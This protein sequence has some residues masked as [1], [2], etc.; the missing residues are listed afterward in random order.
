LLALLTLTVPALLAQEC[1]CIWQGP[2]IKAQQHADLVLLGTVVRR[3]GNSFDV[4][5]DDVMRGETFL[6]TVRVWGLYP[7]TC[8]PGVAQFTPGSQ[9]VL[10]LQ[11]IDSVPPGGF[12]INTPNLSY[13]RKG[14]Y[15]LSRCGIFWLPVRDGLVRG[16]LTE[17]V[18]WEFDEAPMTPVRPELIKRWLQGELDETRLI[19][20]ARFN[21]AVRQLRRET[22][23][24]LQAQ[25][26]PIPTEPE[27]ES[28]P[29]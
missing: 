16:N 6:D 2:F 21:P 13:G 20:A 29:E 27:P 19:K 4:S 10:A 14:D 11:R 18:R 15:A 24:F 5:V 12:D 23:R 28:Q 7:D 22:Q 9:W 1:D 25:E 17:A 3:Q 26:P 8:R